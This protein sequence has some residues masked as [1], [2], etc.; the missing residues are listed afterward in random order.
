M[1]QTDSDQCMSK[2]GAGRTALWTEQEAL[3]PLLGFFLESA[4]PLDGI[5][6]KLLFY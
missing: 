2:L 3:F 5:E 1:F 4:K 6:H